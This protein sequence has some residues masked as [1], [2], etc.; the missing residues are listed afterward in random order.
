MSNLIV[1]KKI[2]FKI[3][4]TGMVI[5]KVSIPVA[6]ATNEYVACDQ[7]LVEDSTGNIHTIY[8]YQVEKILKEAK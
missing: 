3:H 1:G 5:D 8:P 6:S 4:N 7:Y 2:R